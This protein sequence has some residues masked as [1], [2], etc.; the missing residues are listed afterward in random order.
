MV[1]VRSRAPIDDVLLGHLGPAAGDDVVELG[2]GT[3][4]TLLAAVDAVP[5]LRLVGVDIDSESLA[6]A[7][8]LLSGAGARHLLLRAD[9]SRRL[10]LVTGSVSG[11]IC[12][13]VLELLADPAMLLAEASRVLRP[14]GRAVF[15][16]TDFE[17]VAIS[18]G[19]VELTRRVVRAYAATPDPG[20]GHCDGQMGRKLA[21]LVARSP[22]RRRLVDTH[23]VL[24]AE[25]SGPAEVRVRSM[26]ATLRDARPAG[27]GA[28]SP[29]ELEQWRSGLVAA[30]RDGRFLYAHT[31]YIVVADKA[32][33]GSA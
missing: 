13:N 18:G 15:S 32:T 21:A 30:D 24:R 28:L 23:V 9:L 7:G 3:G 6:V 4:H 20:A 31:T 29:A 26:F 10:P 5:D 14:G 12:H 2:C 19:D 33:D 27:G 8:P 1:D 22:L 11:V 17:S 25:L 16:H